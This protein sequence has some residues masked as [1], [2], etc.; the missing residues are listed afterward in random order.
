VVWSSN[1]RHLLTLSGDRFARLWS[2]EGG[3][4]EL[5]RR[6]RIESGV[7]T[8]RAL[9]FV[10]G[11]RPEI[12]S[13]T[14]VVG[15]AGAEA[16]P[17]DAN[18]SPDGGRLATISADG[19]VRAWDTDGRLLF[20]TEPESWAGAAIRWAVDGRSVYG[21]LPDR[22]VEWGDDGTRLQRLGSHS[23]YRPIVALA[24]SPDGR[25]LFAWADDDAVRVFEL[26]PD[27][28]VAEARRRLAAAPDPA[29]T[30]G[31]PGEHGALY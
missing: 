18:W 19:T 26:D 12:W 17:E 13:E 16:L 20:Q 10:R 15:L 24:P 14:G 27:V 30:L 8:A 4:I 7:A 22:V 31:R 28:L 1:H 21:T 29:P 25:R 6:D 3:K 11:A 23:G 5:P 2:T 9:L